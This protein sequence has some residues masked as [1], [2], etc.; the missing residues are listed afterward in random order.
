[1]KETDILDTI[2]ICKTLFVSNQVFQ[3]CEKTNRVIAWISE[4][5]VAED[6]FFNLFFV[7]E[8]SPF[9]AEPVDLGLDMTGDEI[10]LIRTLAVFSENVGKL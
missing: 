2:M 7:W 4:V 6:D 3:N 9:T 10:Q 5:R 8:R 1:M